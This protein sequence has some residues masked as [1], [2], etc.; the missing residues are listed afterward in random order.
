[1]CVC[2]CV[3]ACV[4][5]VCG[6]CVCVHAWVMHVKSQI[7]LLNAQFYYDSIY[8]IYILYIYIYIYLY[9]FHIFM[10]YIGL[11]CN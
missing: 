6:V 5:G 9:I 8:Y 1:M 2:V 3:R 4:R 11:K 10:Y 7:D